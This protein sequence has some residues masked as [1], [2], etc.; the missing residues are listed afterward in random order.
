MSIVLFSTY[1]ECRYTYIP[2]KTQICD[3]A[4]STV[5]LGAMSGLVAASAPVSLNST[6][7]FTQEYTLKA[8]VGFP[9]YATTLMTLVGWFFLCFYMPTG[10]W[11]YVFDYIGAWS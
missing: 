2:I 1:G 11:A 7:C 5:S 8:Q 6:S 9:I 4:N 10:M 3:L